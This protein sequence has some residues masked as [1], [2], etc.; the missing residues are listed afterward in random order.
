MK[1]YGRLV[2]LDRLT[3]KFAQNQPHAGFRQRVLETLPRK[4]FGAVVADQIQGIEIHDTTLLLYVPDPLWY[5]E[6]LKT[7]AFMLAKVNKAQPRITRI[8]IVNQRRPA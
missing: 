4:L 3:E 2:P 1:R 7:T 6:L 5:K 8:R